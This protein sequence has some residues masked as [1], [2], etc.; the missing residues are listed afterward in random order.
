MSEHRENPFNALRDLDPARFRAEMASRWESARVEFTLGH[1]GLGRCKR[2]LFQLAEEQ[3]GV[4][5]LTFVFFH[6]HFPSFPII[7]GA[8]DLGILPEPLHRLQ[9][10]IF[11]EWF[12]N[13]TQLPFMPMYEEL[14]SSTTGLARPL[15]MIF[16]RKGFQQ[17]LVVH[18]GDP[19][20]FVPL[21]GSYF[22]HRGKRDQI[23]VVQPYIA[24]LDQ[25]YRK[26]HADGWKPSPMNPTKERM[27]KLTLPVYD[28]VKTLKE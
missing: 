7:L 2:H 22:A 11:P 13:F 14:Y 16:P 19:S 12:R 1:V 23:L 6:E 4:R 9:K 18:N 24:L 5:R 28:W 3:T 27:K 26:G 21:G 10:A 25:I 15:G 17:G 8:N 20:T